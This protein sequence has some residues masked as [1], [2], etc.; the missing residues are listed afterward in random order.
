[1]TRDE[2]R[3]AIR[4]AAD[5]V[6]SG[7]VTDGEIDLMIESSVGALHDILCAQYGDEYWSTQT[8]IQVSPGSNTQIAWPKLQTTAASPDRGY[9]S[10]YALPDDFVRLVRAEF[11]VGTV[12][13]NSAKMGPDVGPYVTDVDNTWSLSASDKTAY[14]MHRI[15]TAGQRIDM[16]PREWRQTHV[17][18]RL[19]HGPAWAL[20]YARMDVGGG[21]P[22]YERKYVNGNLIEFLPVPAGSYAVQITYVPAPTLLPDHPFPQYLICDCAALCLE[23]QQSDSSTL[24]ALQQREVQRIEQYARTADAAN[25]PMCVDIYASNR[26]GTNRGEPW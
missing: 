14:P 13:R 20:Q 4:R 9:P 1:V 6:D 16:Q 12:T 11:V 5:M 24:R 19:R 21:F 2:L 26:I 15:E 10:A 18:Y 7:F 3:L 22:L 8:W 23:K 17:G 25:P